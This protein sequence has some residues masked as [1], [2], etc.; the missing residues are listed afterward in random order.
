MNTIM[1]WTSKKNKRKT[2]DG[3]HREREKRKESG[4]AK[5]AEGHQ[6]QQP[7]GPMMII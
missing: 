5:T 7:E 3:K 2:K 4:P 1:F 6:S